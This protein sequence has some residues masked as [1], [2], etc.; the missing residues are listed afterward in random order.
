MFYIGLIILLLVFGYIF[1][2]AAVDEDFLGTVCDFLE[3]IVVTLLI[4]A[5]FLLVLVG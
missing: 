1:Y 2:L 5:G 4:F 3:A